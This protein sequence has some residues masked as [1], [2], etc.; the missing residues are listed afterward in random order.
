MK[1]S[2]LRLLI[3]VCCVIA[4][5][6][7]CEPTVQQQSFLK[8]MNK[9][10]IPQDKTFTLMAV[11]AMEH[12]AVV[13]ARLSRSTVVASLMYQNED[14]TVVFLDS[15]KIINK[16]LAS[17]V[18]TL[19]V[20]RPRGNVAVVCLANYWYCEAHLRGERIVCEVM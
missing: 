10:G 18:L 9:A 13:T 12:F 14:G 11:P 16:R 19:R 5:N 17:K 1:T 8:A 3:A 2:V 4:P 20:H 6:V 7:T 15:F